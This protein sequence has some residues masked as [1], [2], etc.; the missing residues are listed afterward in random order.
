MAEE[1][2][3]EAAGKVGDRV[4]MRVPCMSMATLIKDYVGDRHVHFLKVD[5]EES[6]P[7]LFRSCDWTKF[8]PEVIVSE[9]TKPFTNTPVYQE[10]SGR[11]TDADY[12][13]A[14]FDGINAWFVRKESAHL[15]PCFAIPV[16][17]LDQFVPYEQA[18]LKE[19]ITK[20]L[21]EMASLRNGSG[22]PLW[23]NELQRLRDELTW[24]DGPR[25]VR[26]V[27]PIAAFLR[28]IQRKWSRSG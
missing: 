27:L 20:L 17:Q 28:A 10:W 6:E 19:K 13:F 9:G 11:L 12:L 4:E 21:A 8:R 3:P 7:A 2:G 25:A 18:K 14:Y 15:L 1:L 5:I 24:P 22:G 16:N 23:P 26:A